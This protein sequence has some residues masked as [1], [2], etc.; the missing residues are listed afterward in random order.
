MTDPRRVIATAPGKVNLTLGV[1][2]AANDGSHA[3][4]TLCMALDLLD[5]VEVRAADTLHIRVGRI[6]VG[7]SSVATD[8]V[9]TDDR[10]SAA[11]A[12]KLLAEFA[13]LEPRAA[14][15]IRKRVPVGGGMGGASADAAATLLALDALWQTN[16]TR[17]DLAD[18]GARL[19][20]DVPFALLGGVAVGT[21]RGT[22]LTP[23]LAGGSFEWVLRISDEGMPTPAVYRALDAHRE[24]HA[25]HLT[26]SAIPVVPQAALL[27]LR[28]GDPA[29]LADA[30]TNDLQAPALRSR[31]DLAAA[32]EFGEAKGALV[33]IVAGSGPTLAFLTADAASADALAAAFTA[34]GDTAVRASGPAPGARLG[35][36]IR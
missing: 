17:E 29:A 1:G 3:L 14:I 13:G 18:L 32:L 10:N 15:T 7:A 21:G 20:A 2:E 4:A 12:A 34:R 36:R 31:G 26:T 35:Q 23:A 22:E 33:G 30:M 25:P 24:R 9:A 27:A 5:E 16:L 6:R 28:A 8:T 19:G 11:R